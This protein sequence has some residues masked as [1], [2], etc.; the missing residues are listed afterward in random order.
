MQKGLFQ[1]LEILADWK[2]RKRKMPHHPEEEEEEVV[3]DAKQ[4]R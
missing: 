4:G 3:V 1:P 2:S